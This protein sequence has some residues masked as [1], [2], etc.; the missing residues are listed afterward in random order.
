MKDLTVLEA[1]VDEKNVGRCIRLP[2]QLLERKKKSNVSLTAFHRTPGFCGLRL[3]TR[4]PGQAESGQRV[5]CVIS[6]PQLVALCSGSSR[7][8]LI[9]VLSLE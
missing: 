5:T 6:D 8:A 1:S 9:N 2:R 4:H 3:P 7:S